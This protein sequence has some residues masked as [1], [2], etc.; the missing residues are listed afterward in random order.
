M[1]RS[2]MTMSGPNR[3]ATIVLIAQYSEKSGH[4]YDEVKHRCLK[5]VLILNQRKQEVR[6]TP[7]LR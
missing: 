2:H 3:M 4:R 6:V 1:E 5:A 7:L